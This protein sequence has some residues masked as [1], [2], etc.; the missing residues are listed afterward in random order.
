MDPAEVKVESQSS[1]WTAGEVWSQD[2]RCE[3]MQDGD[4]HGGATR[5]PHGAC[6]PAVLSGMGERCSGCLVPPREKKWGRSG[7]RQK[8]GSGQSL[9]DEH[10]RIAMQRAGG[11]VWQSRDAR[12]D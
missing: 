2:P 7:Q 9:K 5:E 10:G 1:A 11:S 6:C 8:T 3:D 4:A 12:V